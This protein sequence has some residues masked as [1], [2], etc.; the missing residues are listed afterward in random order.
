MIIFESL[1]KG[2]M[3]ELVTTD[4]KEKIINSLLCGVNPD[5]TAKE[6]KCALSVVLAVMG[7]GDFSERISEHL[8][9]EIK[10][11]GVAALRNIKTIADDEAANKNTRLRANQ[12]LVEN[13]MNISKLGGSDGS[14]STMTQDQLARRLQE[15][16]AEAIKR[17]KPIDTGVI[18]HTPQDELSQ[19]LD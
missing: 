4:L 12:W 10:V 5:T 19:M 16:Q 17:A 2:G 3:N 18:E 15:L 6:H 9:K 1:Y 13:A 14:P 11:A 8:E 7:S